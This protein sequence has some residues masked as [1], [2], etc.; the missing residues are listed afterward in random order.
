LLQ[1]LGTRAR[2]VN[3]IATLLHALQ[4]NE[5]LDQPSF[6]A[7]IAEEIE[8]IKTH[9]CQI[10]ISLPIYTDVIKLSFRL[11]GN[12]K[13]TYQLLTE[14]LKAEQIRFKARS[15]QIRYER[16]RSVNI[17]SLNIK[18]IKRIVKQLRS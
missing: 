16:K 17:S 15:E 4:A 1:L 8:L 7:F 3:K 12:K 14:N 9:Y 6:N 2:N 13:Q 5:T 11:F 10:H 18:L